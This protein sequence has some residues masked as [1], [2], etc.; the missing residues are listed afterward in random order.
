M[1]SALI[2]AA[3]AFLCYTAKVRGIIV[4][5]PGQRRIYPDDW[6]K[7][8]A[9]NQSQSIASGHYGSVSLTRSGGI[10]FESSCW[11]GNNLLMIYAIA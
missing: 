1:G 6:P 4:E 5:I 8:V 9:D 11:F 3:I 7:N 10:S 2:G